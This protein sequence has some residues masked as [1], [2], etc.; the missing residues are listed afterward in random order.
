[1]SLRIVWF[2]PDASGT[3]PDVASRKGDQE[4]I[5][6]RCR[7]QPGRH[8]LRPRVQS[9]ESLQECPTRDETMYGHPPYIQS[10]MDYLCR[11][12]RPQLSCLCLLEIHRRSGGA[13]AV[14]QRQILGALHTEL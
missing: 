10:P 12:V 1:D 5:E 7:E 8:A 2:H 14:S 9:A 13:A 6:T 4:C 11:S 3:T